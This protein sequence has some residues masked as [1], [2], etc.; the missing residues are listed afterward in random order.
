[1]GTGTSRERRKGFENRIAAR[2]GD[3]GRNR[4]SPV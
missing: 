3:P 1:M 4:T 2:P